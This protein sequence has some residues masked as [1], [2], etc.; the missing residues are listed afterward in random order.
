MRKFRL[1]IELNMTINELIRM[2]TLKGEPVES[3]ENVFGIPNDKYVER[4]IVLHDNVFW[5]VYAILDNYIQRCYWE[6]I[7]DFATENQA[8][9]Y[10][11]GL[12][13]LQDNDEQ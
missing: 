11:D 12:T 1:M 9:I 10:Y 4:A 13:N 2:I 8:R 6:D 5:V 7:Q 3:N